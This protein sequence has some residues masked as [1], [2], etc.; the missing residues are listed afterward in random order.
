MNWLKRAKQGI[1]TWRKK[2]LPDGLWL[3][4]PSCGMILYRKELKKSHSVCQKCSY[5]F[6]IGS[7]EYIEILSDE[8]SFTEINTSLKSEDPLSFKDSKKYTSRLKDAVKKSGMNSAIKTGVAAMGGRSIAIGVLDFSFMG[9]SMG[10]VVG[11]KIVRLVDVALSREIPLVIVSSSGGAR[12]QES[13][14]SLMQMAKTSAAISKISRASLPYISVLTNPT[15]GGVAASFA[16]QGDIIVAEPK[17]LIGFAGPRVIK[18]TVGEELPKGFQTSEFLLEHGM[19]DMICG[20]GKLKSVLSFALD[21]LMHRVASDVVE[22]REDDI[23][24]ISFIQK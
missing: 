24:K 19:I 22:D 15:T 8:N 3:K 14:L 4:C 18:E 9:G 10:S 11:E 23:E 6:R 20:R 13:I 16:F 5:H 1:K 7:S 17:A 12:M 21:S 2:S